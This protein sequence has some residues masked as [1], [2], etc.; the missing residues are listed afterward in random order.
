MR[1]ANA[2]RH[3]T[4]LHGDDMAIDRPLPDRL[5][6]LPGRNQPMRRT[7]FAFRLD[8]LN[9][10]GVIVAS[11][12]EQDLVPLQPYRATPGARDGAAYQLAGDLP[13]ALAIDGID[14]GCDS[15]DAARD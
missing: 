13:L 3:R 11:H 9:G 15:R 7:D 4:H 14:S 6:R 1:K 8:K 10:D 5:A 12:V 2:R